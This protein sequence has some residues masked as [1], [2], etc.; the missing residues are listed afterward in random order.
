[1]FDSN[2]DLTRNNVAWF[3]NGCC[4][5]RQASWGFKGIAS[6]KKFLACFVA[7]C[8]SCAQDVENVVLV[9]RVS[10]CSFFF[11]DRKTVLPHFVFFSLIIVKS[12]QLRRRRQIAKSCK[13]C[14]VRVIIF[15]LT[16]VFSIFCFSQV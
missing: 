6:G 10:G 2:D 4:A 11:R 16:C 8:E 12:L 1:M 7:H 9:I 14:L 3:F 5:Y 15:S 13:Y